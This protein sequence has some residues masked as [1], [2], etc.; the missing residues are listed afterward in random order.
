MCWSSVARVAI[1]SHLRSTF[2]SE[3]AAFQV[4]EIKMFYVGEFKMFQVAKLFSHYFFIISF[5]FLTIF[6]RISLRHVLRS[7]LSWDQEAA[8]FQ[9]DEIKMFRVAEI[10]MFQVAEIKMQSVKANKWS[11][12]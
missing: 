3:T 9:V 11:R 4:A 6:S 2:D 10:K 12:F 7:Y 1:L 5:K 8:A